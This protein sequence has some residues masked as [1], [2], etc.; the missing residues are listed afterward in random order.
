MKSQRLQTIGVLILIIIL[1]TLGIFFRLNNLEKKI[2]W[3]D[4]VHTSLRISGYRKAD[5]A[6]LVPSNRVIGIKELHKFQQLSPEKTW[7]DTIF[8]LAGNA[9][10]APLYYILARLAMQW[11]D[12]SIEVTRGL[13]AVLSL[14]VFPGIYWLC[15]ELFGLPLVGGIAMALVAISPFHVLYAQEARQYS[16]WTATILFSSAA[17]Q[18][19]IRLQTTSAWFVYAVTVAVSLYSHLISG[20]V[21]LGHGIYVLVYQLFCRDKDENY[22]VFSGYF[23][24]TVLGFITLIPW[25]LL[26]IASGSSI[27]NWVAREI[28][29]FTLFKRWLLNLSAIFFD[30]QV[31]YNERLFDVEAG[32]DGNI[33][34]TVNF[35]IYLIVPILILVG[36]AVYF[37]CRQ[38]TGRIWLSLITLIVV[39]AM[40]MV[41]PDIISGGQRS[42]IARYL[43]PSYLGIQIAVAYLLA[44]KITGQRLVWRVVAIAIFTAGI[45]SCIVSG[46]A[47]TWWNKYSCYYN[48]RVAKIINQT[49]R[50][51]VISSSERVSRL[52]SLSYKLNPHTNLLL[53]ENGNL[54]KISEKFS[55]VFLFRPSGKLLEKIKRD[56]IYKIQPVY[57]I[58]S[59]WK[60]KIKN[61]PLVSP[62]S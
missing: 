24:A 60:L 29:F 19:A 14:L 55:D 52:V 61:S 35:L 5:F 62:K 1:V 6:E 3:I 15:L 26:Y 23:L 2:Y 38:T 44:V 33:F 4:E 57:T 53:V 39:P 21:C 43:I 58:G 10:H 56:D 20:L 45:I 50:P 32:Q 12:S 17:L 16:L 7:S 37:V 30:M 13:A 18:R 41:L 34:A 8:A 59:L 36:Y 40:A 48:I 46:Q 25:M 31:I 42:G 27:G 28:P 11:F 22:S 47:E 9:E 49:P 54:P 51:L